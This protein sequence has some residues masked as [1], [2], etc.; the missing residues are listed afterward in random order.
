MLVA[1]TRVVC[2]VDKKL[3]SIREVCCIFDFHSFIIKLQGN[4]FV[5]LFYIILN[6]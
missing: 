6:Q 1:K 2:Y 4:H 5:R 3:L